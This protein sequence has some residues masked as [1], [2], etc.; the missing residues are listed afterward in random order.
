MFWVFDEMGSPY[1][2]FDINFMV[3]VLIVMLF[4]I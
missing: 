4:Y 1:F 3:L 2:Q